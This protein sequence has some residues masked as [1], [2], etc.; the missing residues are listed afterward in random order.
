MSK[1]ILILMA[2]IMMG[3]IAT[4]AVGII[5]VW[6][7]GEHNVHETAEIHYLNDEKINLENKLKNLEKGSPEYIKTLDEINNT[8]HHINNIKSHKHN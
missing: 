5:F 7:S 2:V 1:I 6:N 3:I 8:T 4:V